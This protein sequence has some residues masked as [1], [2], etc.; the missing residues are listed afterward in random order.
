MS[1]I[2][3]LGL[4]ALGS[5]GAMA[6]AALI[7]AAPSHWRERLLPPLLA[8]SAGSLPGLPA[9]N[10]RRHRSGWPWPDAGH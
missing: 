7:A 3:V 2:A 4:A 1:F 6:G 8:Y 9:A 5:V 10:C